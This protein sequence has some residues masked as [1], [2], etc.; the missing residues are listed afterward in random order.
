MQVLKNKHFHYCW[1][2][3]KDKTS[4]GTAFPPRL[5]VSPVKVQISCQPEEALDP[6]LRGIVKEEYLMIIMG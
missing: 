1:K 4:L 3:K 5:Q 6:W 2:G